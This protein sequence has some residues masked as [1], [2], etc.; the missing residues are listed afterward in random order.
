MNHAALVPRPAINHRAQKTPEGTE[1]TGA[2]TQLVVEIFGVY[3]KP[4]QP[5]S[6]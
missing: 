2:A 3:L 6:L 5:Q 4:S 1:R